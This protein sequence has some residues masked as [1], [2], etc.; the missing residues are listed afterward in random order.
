[1]GGW[2]ETVPTRV[3]NLTVHLP[4]VLTRRDGTAIDSAAA[5]FE[6]AGV[7]VIVDAGP[8]ADPLQPRGGAANYEE[9]DVRVGGMPARRVSYDEPDGTRTVAVHVRNPPFTVTAMASPNVPR[10]VLDNIVSTIETA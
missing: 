4:A 10:D 2:S 6:A 8:F 7:R 1:M 9:H 5:V 3:G